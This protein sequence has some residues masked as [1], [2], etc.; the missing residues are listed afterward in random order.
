MPLTNRLNNQ[1]T[2]T[3]EPDESRDWGKWGET[4]EIG[5]IPRVEQQ[6]QESASGNEMWGGL[7]K[8][9]DRLL[10]IG[11][12]DYGSPQPNK[13][14]PTPPRPAPEPAPPAPEPEPYDFDAAVERHRQNLR[15]DIDARW[16]QRG[17]RRERVPFVPKTIPDEDFYDY[18]DNYDVEPNIDKDILHA[19]RYEQEVVVPRTNKERLEGQFEDDTLNPTAALLEAVPNNRLAFYEAFHEF[20]NNREFPEQIVGSST[21]KLLNE[22]KSALR[23]IGSYIHK[24]QVRKA[25][26]SEEEAEALGTSVGGMKILFNEL[27]RR[28]IDPPTRYL[29]GQ[30][31]RPDGE[32]GGELY[33]RDRFYKKIKDDP[34]LRNLLKREKHRPKIYRQEAREYH[35]LR[36]KHTQREV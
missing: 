9:G 29:L 16:Q 15:G 6:A 22:Y 12:W 30:I 34:L 21:E 32:G 36:T 14:L 28:G 23:L 26:V 4:S 17:E 2:F 7:A 3:Q 33:P 25:P 31:W 18:M 8:A 10:K 13:P 24:I 19:H 20:L 35:A 11:G 27:H 1:P 5:E